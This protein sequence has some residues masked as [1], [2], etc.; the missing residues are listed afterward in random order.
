MGG[1]PV[2][3]RLKWKLRMLD[4]LKRSSA[5]LSRTAEIGWVIHADK[6]GFIWDEPKK[7]LREP[8]SSLHPK[9]VRYCPAVLEHEARLFEIVCP[10]S[11]SLR[12]NLGSAKEPPTLINAAGDKSEIRPKHLGQMVTL[13]SRKEWRHPER[14]ILQIVTPYLFL[15]DEAVYMTQLPPICHYRSPSLPGVMIGGR[16]PIHIWPRALMWAFEWY[17]AKQDLVL[18]RGEP[19][20]YVRFE[21]QDP[22][23]PVRLV[24]A[25]MT[26]QL[27]E[28]LKGV[29]SVTNYMNR[30]FSLFATARARRPKRLLVHKQR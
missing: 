14:P 5:K 25:E 9:S 4:F 12:V 8:A 10:V 1:A 17:D 6:A 29:T 24:E 3:R 27:E 20:F 21:S 18:R 23:R 19:W 7:L 26:P 28:F 22:S 15:A 16:F 11:M 13:V 30:T 2:R